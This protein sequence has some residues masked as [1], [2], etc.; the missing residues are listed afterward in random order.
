MSLSMLARTPGYCTLI[1]SSRPSRVVARWTCP[2]EAAAK[3]R[4][5]KRAKR[6][7]Q[8]CA[9]FGVEHALKLLRR[10][11]RR[12]GAQRRHH[13]RHLGRQDEPVSIDSIWPSFI[14]APA[15]P[16]EVAGDARRGRG[17]EEGAGQARPF[18]PR[19]LADAGGD[20][21]AEDARRHA[22][23]AQHPAHPAARHRM[24]PGGM[25]VLRHAAPLRRCQGDTWRACA[26][27]WPARP[28]Q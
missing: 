27:I 14:A 16:P 6:P 8:P 7:Y 18:A 11:V 2:I 28:R 17:R 3:G 4:T 24:R 23:K 26:A 15:H 20:H 10:H 19:H 13:R 5:S 12:V 1:A 22:A 21:V 9:P 25:V